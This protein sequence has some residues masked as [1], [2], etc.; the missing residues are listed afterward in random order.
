MEGGTTEVRPFQL[1]LGSIRCEHYVFS[2]GLPLATTRWVRATFSSHCPLS[3]NQCCW[4]TSALSIIFPLKFFGNAVNQT[5]GCWV[6]SKYS[7][8]LCYAAPPR[9]HNAWWQHQ[10]QMKDVS[11]CT[12]KLILSCKKHSWLLS[13]TA[14]GASFKNILATSTNRATFNVAKMFF[15]WGSISC[16][17]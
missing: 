9:K 2:T 6:R 8:S 1:Y 3:S 4:L 11:F 16:H 13:V 12:I 14:D 7:T 17:G 15:E 5:W 10:S